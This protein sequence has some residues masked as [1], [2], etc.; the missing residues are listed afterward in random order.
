MPV[1][2]YGY[3]DSI[4]FDYAESIDINS[5]L[6]SSAGQAVCQNA[7]ATTI[8]SDSVNCRALARTVTAVNGTYLYL[9]RK[10]VANYYY[11]YY[12]Y[13][14]GNTGSD[15]MQKSARVWNVAAVNRFG[16]GT[17]VYSNG[18]SVPSNNGAVM[19]STSSF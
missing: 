19:L 17:V 9:A 6:S 5:T 4:T 2:T 16:L 14:F 1:N 15:A 18:G 10:R 8:A 11:I 3:V 7:I 12:I 13:L